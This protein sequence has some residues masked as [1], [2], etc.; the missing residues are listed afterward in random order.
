MT[1]RVG[2]GAAL[3]AGAL[4]LLLCSCRTAPP[5][6]VPD[7][8]PSAQGWD[9]Y[10]SGF[11]EWF[12]A[13]HPDAAVRA[14]RHEFD[15]RLPDWTE[16]GLRSLAGRLHA[17]RERAQAFEPARLDARQRL[18]REVIL[19][20]IDGEIFWLE[21]A[22]WPLRSPAFYGTALDPNVYVTREYAPLARRLEAY[23]AYAKAVPAA[24]EQ[25][26]ANLRTPMPRTFIQN[27][28][29]RF[30]GLARFYERDVPAVFREVP[31]ARLQEQ[32]LRANRGAI[33][34]MRSLDQWLEAQEGTATEDFALGPQ[35]FLEMLR[36]TE[37]VD[38]PLAR[39]K[40]IGEEDLQRNLAALGEACAAF[41]PGRSVRECVARVNADKP[42]SVI[43]AAARQLDDLK[44]FVQSRALVTIPGPEQALVRESPPYQRYNTAYISIP[45]PYEKDLPSI[46]YIAPPDPAWT[47]A[48][49]DAYIPAK[50][51]LLF[52][53][54]HEV[55]P[56]HFLQFL[57]A[58]RAPSEADRVFY[59]YAFAEG[60]AHYCEE[61]MWEAGLS[62]GDP[63]VHVGQ[64]VN[65]LLRDV[66]Y[67]SAIGLHTEGMT[68]GQSEAMFREAAFQDPGN[69][70][71]QAAR[72]T[73]DPAYG[74]YTL[75]KLMIRRLRD[76]WTASRGGRSS[77]KDFHDRFL[78]Y[79][80][81]PIPVV[82]S[83]MLG[84]GAGAPL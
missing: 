51:D 20:R 26:R 14:G 76:D 11:L 5:A 4:V 27:G 46:Y 79:G 13:S 82:R 54:A 28:R 60:W 25:I 29:I 83:E 40:Q 64:L 75:G 56:G 70:R 48:E 81:P 3:L 43:D 72:G 21:T 15:G 68:V 18:E 61:M 45:G 36:A 66:R 1:K 42:A 84:A 30:G 19:S 2:P 37:R 12:F 78:S 62:D 41:D 23:I 38:V 53:S 58:H 69:A 47:R 9:R 16:A 33:A 31:D 59:S 32:F 55:W 34:A 35:K 74:N 24:A 77:W 80:A 49:Q 57:H 71:Q 10:S 67:L 52:I 50:A 17:E 73:F 7:A 6:P 63:E 22:Q 65:A 8:A 44:A 39:L